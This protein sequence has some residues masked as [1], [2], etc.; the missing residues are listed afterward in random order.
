MVNRIIKNTTTRSE[1]EA[2]ASCHSLRN[3]F[4]EN[5]IY[6]YN[7]QDKYNK[8]EQIKNTLIN[9]AQKICEA[10]PECDITTYNTL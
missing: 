1:L 6:N 2:L 10:D 7:S 4:K 5:S 9:K 3:K 8:I